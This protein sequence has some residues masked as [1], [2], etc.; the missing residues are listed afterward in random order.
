MHLVLVGG[1]SEQITEAHAR[2]QVNRDMQRAA[3]TGAARLEFN[4]PAYVGSGAQQTFF[5]TPI[6]N[7]YLTVQVLQ[8]ENGAAALA[9]G[10][11]LLQSL[12][13][14]KAGGSTVAK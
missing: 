6:L 3:P 1:S 8:A 12:Q 14:C 4:L 11:W 10:S 13:Q 9:Q 5:A 7:S 2:G